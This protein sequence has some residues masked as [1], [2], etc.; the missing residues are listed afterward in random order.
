MCWLR[1]ARWRRAGCWQSTLGVLV[2]DLQFHGE[3]G[4]SQSVLMNAASC[5]VGFDVETGR[6]KEVR[7]KEI[8]K[9]GRWR[10]Y[11]QWLSQSPAR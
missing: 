11:R 10:R 4:S 1:R 3:K 9:E 2:C 7:D 8:M 5:Q 6:G